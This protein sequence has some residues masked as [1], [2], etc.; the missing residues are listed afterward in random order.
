MS[1]DEIEAARVKNTASKSAF[2]KHDRFVD[3]RKHDRFVDLLFSI[4]AVMLLS[5]GERMSPDEIEAARVKN[6]A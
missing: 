4:H 2:R 5:S 6:T 3:F 1:P